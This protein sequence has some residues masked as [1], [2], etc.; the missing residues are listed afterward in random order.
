MKQKHFSNILWGLIFSF[1]LWS[2]VI[3]VLNTFLQE[4][5]TKYQ[6]H[7]TQAFMHFLLNTA[8][9]SINNSKNIVQ[10]SLW[11][12]SG[13]V[14]F[15][16]PGTLGKL[17]CSSQAKE[18]SFL[19]LGYWWIVICHG[20]SKHRT[21]Y[22]FLLLFSQEWWMEKWSKKSWRPAWAEK[23]NRYK[24]DC[25]NQTKEKSNPVL[26]FCPLIANTAHGKY[27]TAFVWKWLTH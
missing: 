27:C 20:L 26:F 10:D 18:W 16:T 7:P 24:E 4:I 14:I 22:L 23:S 3:I 15:L 2:R 6:G 12:R 8:V 19:K 21:P 11:F 1:L 13:Q 5:S 17:Q 25:F 9:I